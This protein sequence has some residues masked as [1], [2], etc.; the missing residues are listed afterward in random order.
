[1][2]DERREGHAR[3]KEGS[4]GGKEGDEPSAIQRS[5]VE[6]GC[7]DTLPACPAET[8]PLLAEQLRPPSNLGRGGKERREGE[9]VEVGGL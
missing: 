5:V 8:A 3:S 7:I 1:M 2:S 9:V 6:L 4:G